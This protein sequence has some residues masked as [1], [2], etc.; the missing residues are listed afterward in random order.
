MPKK[1]AWT[2]VRC[3]IH[4]GGRV[5]RRPPLCRPGLPVAGPV[6]GTDA[7]PHRPVHRAGRPAAGGPGASL[8]P[9]GAGHPDAP[10]GRHLPGGGTA[11]FAPGL[12]GAVSHRLHRLLP[13]RVPG[14]PPGLC[15]EKRDGTAAARGFGPAARPAGAPRRG[16]GGG[17]ARGGP[18]G[19][20][21]QHRLS[22]TA[23]AHHLDPHP[24]RP[25]DRA[26]KAGDGA[27]AA[28]PGG[29]LPD[30]QEFCGALAVRRA[31]RPHRHPVVRRGVGAHQP[32]PRGGGAAQFSA[33]H[34]NPAAPAEA[35]P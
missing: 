31:V 5:R 35:A 32:G 19:A 29:L 15:A 28:G 1:G 18:A 10:A 8:C 3:P 12:P 11:G 6:P 20:P 25:G 4:A 2:H 30:P 23:G 27:A 17:G 22:G 26:R 9:G 34:R 33:L 13:G 16:I 14:T 24:G 21:E 7:P